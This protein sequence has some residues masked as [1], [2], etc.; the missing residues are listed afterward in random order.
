M[1]IDCLF[2]CENSRWSLWERVPVKLRPDRRVRTHSQFPETVTPL[3]ESTDA[4]V[5]TKTAYLMSGL[6]SAVIGPLV[7]ASNR[8]PVITRTEHC[9]SMNRSPDLDW[10]PAAGGLPHR[11][12]VHIQLALSDRTDKVC[13]LIEGLQR[14]GAMK[15]SVN[16]EDHENARFTAG[17]LTTRFYLSETT[18]R[19][20][21]AVSHNANGGQG[22]IK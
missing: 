17:L 3:T 10:N 20:G 8:W 5:R 22:Q 13:N 1:V 16:F 11:L 21:C 14:T 19:L 9:L 6:T 18:R 12:Y 15:V 2:E 4:F 7:A